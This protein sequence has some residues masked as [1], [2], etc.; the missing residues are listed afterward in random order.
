MLGRPWLR[1]LLA[2]LWA[3]C[4]ELTR[5]FGRTT[6]VTLRVP[7]GWAQSMEV[8]IRR[9]TSRTISGNTC[10]LS[11]Y[12]KHSIFDSWEAF[13]L[14][15]YNDPTLNRARFS[16]LFPWSLLNLLIN[17][18]CSG[19]CTGGRFEAITARVTLRIKAWVWKEWLW[20]VQCSN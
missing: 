13:H 11:V 10:F 12:D 14:I 16:F 20:L 15:Q 9:Q 2:M 8:R 4:N 19:D 1:V 6:P 3:F 17:K 5:Y 18:Y 7:E